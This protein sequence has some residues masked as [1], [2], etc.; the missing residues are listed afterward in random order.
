MRPP[1]HAKI[2][3]RARCLLGSGLPHVRE[4]LFL[5]ERP[6]AALLRSSHAEMHL[7]DA[8]LRRRLRSRRHIPHGFASLRGGGVPAEADDALP[9]GGCLVKQPRT[10]G[11]YRD[12]RETRHGRQGPMR[13]AWRYRH[14]TVSAQTPPEQISVWHVWSTHNCWSPSA[15]GAMKF[16]LSAKILALLQKRVKLIYG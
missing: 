4:G 8:A 5:V 13:G 1:S 10:S 2:L 6:E 14:I 11:L 16:L 15:H 9:R 12:A 3:A 7:A